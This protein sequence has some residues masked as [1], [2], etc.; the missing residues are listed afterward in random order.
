MTEIV[1]DYKPTTLDTGFANAIAVHKDVHIKS[2]EQLQ[3][4][5]N[6][7]RGVFK[8]ASI[9]AYALYISNRKEVAPENVKYQSFI[10]A[11]AMHCKTYFNL[12]DIN[13]VAGHG[14]DLAYLELPSTAAYKALKNIVNHELSQRDLAFFIEDWNNQLTGLVGD[15]KQNIATTVSAIRNVNIKRETN[16]DHKTGNFSQTTSVLDRIEAASEYNLPDFI[17]FRFVPY[18]EFPEITVK[19]RLSLL[20]EESKPCFTLRWI[21]Q[22]I[23]QEQLAEDFKNILNDRLGD[24]V[25]LNIGSFGLGD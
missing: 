16:S 25:Q 20:T 5:R 1:Q 24:V 13:N 21:G 2:L 11:D 15:E 12:L 7:F 10:N 3:A 19:L 23:Q 14:D 8:T 9:A 17:L 4:N 18:P 22:E 6:R